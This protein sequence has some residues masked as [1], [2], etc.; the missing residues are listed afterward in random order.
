[1]KKHIGI[2]TPC[3]EDRSKMIPLENADFCKKCAMEVQ[4][5]SNL[6]P[7]EIK[8]QLYLRMN[9][10]V[11]ARMTVDQE[12][13][14]N[15]DFINWKGSRQDQ[16]RRAM[17]F[18]L[19]IVFGMTLFSCS[20]PDAKLALTSAH[21][22][23][24]QSIRTNVETIT[25]DLSEIDKDSIQVS[26]DLDMVGSGHETKR[27][28]SVTPP[29]SL[30][31]AEQISQLPQSEYLIAGGIGWAPEYVEYI[32]EI[33][34]DT[35][36]PIETENLVNSDIPE[37]FEVS[38]YPNPTRGNSKVA[39]NL[40]RGTESLSVVILD[41]EGRMV[42]TIYSGEIKPSATEFDIELNDQVPG[43]YL[44]SVKTNNN[45]QTFRL[46]KQ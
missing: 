36:D 14:L 26:E 18:S 9:Q 34:E 25:N 42:Q 12:R 5:F 45:S 2:Q 39:L 10:S 32:E 21:S 11:C 24:V 41:M 8:L 43:T 30:I 46:V 37:Y 38:V 16:M 40:P 1:M 22:Q 44:V 33:H 29:D 28:V 19:F 27:I 20:N 15:Q 6:S 3:S 17:F 4:D 35:L 7:E 23:F 13:Q 31:S